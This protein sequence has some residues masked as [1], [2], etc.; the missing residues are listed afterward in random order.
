MT[1][2][3][4]SVL[5]WTRAPLGVDLALCVAALVYLRRWF[6]L[7]A[8][9]PHLI[10]AWQAAA[11][12]TGLASVWAAIG[13]PLEALDDISLSV[14]M[15][16]HLLL[17][18]IAPPL[19]LLGAPALPLLR[20][21]PQSIAHG[22]VGP[23]LRWRFV[24]SIGRVI[25]NPAF[26]WLAATFAL[27]GWHIPAVFELALRKDWLHEIEHASF[28]SAGL[29]FWWPVIQPW[30]STPRW[31]RWSIPLYLFLATLPCDALS[32][33]LAFCDRVVY[34]SYL[35]AAQVFNISPLQDQ[36][37]AA[38]LMW[39]CITI[40]LVVP[41]VIV[42]LQ[43]LSPARATFARG[44]VNQPQ[45]VGVATPADSLYSQP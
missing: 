37:R 41:A 18:S 6:R 39:T 38:A 15:A 5:L 17:M 22:V 40:I 2:E 28:F 30:P 3:A 45:A 9:F 25:T 21:L 10:A 16:Q 20:G 32:A 33:F 42:T 31:P 23:F 35:S 44:D 29:L 19:I 24:K 7:R 11:F 14:H 1:A 13:S 36:E 43:L 34:P 27:I 12:L 26:C 4:Q 8:A